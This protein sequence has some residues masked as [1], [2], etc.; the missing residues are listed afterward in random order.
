M[1]ADLCAICTFAPGFSRTAP[2][3]NGGGVFALTEHE[4]I[5]VS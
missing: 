1:P 4:G 2:L 5:G 3:D